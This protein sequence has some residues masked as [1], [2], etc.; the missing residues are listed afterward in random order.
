MRR[1]ER[2][3]APKADAAVRIST[4]HDRFAN[5]PKGAE[6]A[7]AVVE[8]PY[9]DPELARRAKQRMWRNLK[10]DTLARLHAQKHI[11]DLAFAAGRAWQYCFYRAA[12]NKLPAIDPTRERVDCDGSRAGTD[13]ALRALQRLASAE[14]AAQKLAEARKTIGILAHGIIEDVLGHGLAVEAAAKRRGLFSRTGIDR[15]GWLLRVSLSE[16][17]AVF[18]LSTRGRPQ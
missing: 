18:G 11:D 14:D 17:A 3:R 16:L 15:I 2:L 10:H 6:L 12:G 5:P 4:L 9:S 7:I 8:E 13:S 1:R